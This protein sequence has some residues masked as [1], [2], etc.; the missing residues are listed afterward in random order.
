MESNK[1][2]NPDDSIDQLFQK[3]A[4]ELTDKPDPELW[5]RLDQKLENQRTRKSI[6]NLKRWTIAAS[7]AALLCIGL[8][9]SLYISNL[10][11]KKDIAFHAHYSSHLEALDVN[12]V[13]NPG[14]YTTMNVKD[15]HHFLIKN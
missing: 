4:E 14:F 5:N 8:V 10:Q 13:S 6:I 9:S 2:Y 11:V 15:L 1:Y 3:G 7:I 12:S